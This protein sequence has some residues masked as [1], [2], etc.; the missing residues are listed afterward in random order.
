MN[1]VSLIEKPDCE[2]N[3]VDECSMSV[4][5][6]IEKPDCECNV[7]ECCVSVVCSLRSLIVSVM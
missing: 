6:L 7:D 4:V 2:C 3:V 5:S 1:V